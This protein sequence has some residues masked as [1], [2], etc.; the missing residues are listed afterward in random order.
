[1]F[2]FFS[3]VSIDYRNGSLAAT[4]LEYTAIIQIVYV[5]L[6]G[7]KVNLREDICWDG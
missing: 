6:N 3:A 4:S 1:M 7:V 5:L 2:L